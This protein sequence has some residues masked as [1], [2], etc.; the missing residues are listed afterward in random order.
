[1]AKS[2]KTLGLSDI[3][4]PHLQD[5]SLEEVVALFAEEQK[6]KLAQ[7]IVNSIVIDNDTSALK[8]LQTIMDKQGLG[9][10]KELPITD[11]RYKEIIQTAAR[12]LAAGTLS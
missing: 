7:A 12:G 9:T 5:K 10:N 6:G 4:P 1:M 2:N 8:I 3:L 11:A